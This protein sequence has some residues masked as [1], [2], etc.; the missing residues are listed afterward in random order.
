MIE[1]G[2]IRKHNLVIA[3]SKDYNFKYGLLGRD[4]FGN[5]RFV[6]DRQNKVVRFHR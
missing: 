4:F 2:P 3:V 6:V 5:R 1:L